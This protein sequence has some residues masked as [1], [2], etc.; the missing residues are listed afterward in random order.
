MS[1]YDESKDK[2]LWRGQIGNL[3]VSVQQYNGGEAKVQIGPRVIES[4]NGGTINS[5]AGRLTI[6]ELQWITEKADEIKA[7]AGWKGKK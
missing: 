1:A 7:A 2:R 3:V 6:D 4:K 5:K